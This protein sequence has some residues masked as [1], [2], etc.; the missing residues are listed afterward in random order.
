V[1]AQFGVFKHLTEAKGAFYRAILEVFGRAK[2]AFRIH[3]RVQ[4][5]ARDLA[6]QGA[7]QGAGLEEDELTR[8]LTQLRDWG[9]LQAHHDTSEVSTVEEFRN[10]R[11]LYQMTPA[12]EA[13]ERAI[14]HYLEVLVQPGELQ[15]A[16]LG[17]ILAQLTELAGLAAEEAAPDAGK[18]YRL[19]RA[20]CERFDELTARAQSFVGSV[21][22]GAE[23][24]GMDVAHFLSYKEL[25]VEYL[26]RFIG[27]LVVATAAINEVI[28]RIEESGSGRLLDVA[29]EREVVDQLIVSDV[30]RQEARAR[31]EARWQGLRAWFV[32]QPGVASQAE[33]LRARARAAIPALLSAVAAIHERRVAR[34]DR[35][36]DLRELARWFACADTEAEAHR[37]WRAAF[38]LQPARHLS[39]DAVT[40]AARDEQPVSASTSWLAA[41]PIWVA[42][43]LRQAGRHAPP[44]RPRPI[45]DR[46]REKA[47]LAELVAAEAE[48]VRRARAR[49]ATGARLRLSQLGALDAAEFELFLGLLG[50]A[51]AAGAAQGG[52]VEAVSSDGSLLVRLEPCGDGTTARIDTPAGRFSGPDHFFEVR[53]LW[54]GGGEVE[55]E[56]TAVYVGAGGVGR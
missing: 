30:D 27:E 45:V 29:A 40:L 13:A 23:L 35:V 19:L 34:S 20:L 25:L 5:V 31:W 22:R 46:G 21:Q 18:V 53:E 14:A 37:L 24:H 3:L 16:A 51:L 6:A 55:V 52:V 12:G 42:P 2:A 43:R 11:F 39:I 54:G 15:A 10:A 44:G 28:A 48:Q 41:P 8:A 26:E 1:A 4:E 9:N 38:G 56:E 50:D 33:V 36:A 17:D 7:A 32:G 49:L 47:Y